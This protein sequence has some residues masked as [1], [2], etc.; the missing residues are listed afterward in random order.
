MFKAAGSAPPLKIKKF[1]LASSA[2]IQNVLDFLRKQ[3][4]YKVEESLVWHF[5]HIDYL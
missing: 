2:T 3:L 4:K 5:A 1:K